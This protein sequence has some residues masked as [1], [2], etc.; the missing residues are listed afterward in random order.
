MQARELWRRL[1]GYAPN[2]LSSS[3]RHRFARSHHQNGLGAV[4]A[5][6]SVRFVNDNVN[7]TVYRN[8]SSRAGGEV[9]VIEK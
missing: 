1:V 6:A 9:S 2:S 5:D 3:G 8:T 4:M 7:M